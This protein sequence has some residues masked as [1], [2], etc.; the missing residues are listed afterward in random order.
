M[1]QDE[2]SIVHNRI[3]KIYEAVLGRLL[4][5]DELVDGESLLD[6]LLID[7]LSSLQIIIKIEQE[8]NVIIE[9]DD[10]AIRLVDSIQLLIDYILE[11]QRGDN[12]KEK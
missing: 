3:K 8:F 9:D 1:Q 11:Y 7:S 4:T 2:R 6:R 12:G 5:G 10:V